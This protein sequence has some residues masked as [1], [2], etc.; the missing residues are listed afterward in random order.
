MA[1][2][3]KILVLEDEQNVGL[4]LVERLQKEGFEVLDTESLFFFP[5]ALK[6]LRFLERTLG[7]TPLGAQ[8]LVLGAR[9]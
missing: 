4:T 5:R 1:D 8:Y 6:G 2:A 3:V 7:R 9:V